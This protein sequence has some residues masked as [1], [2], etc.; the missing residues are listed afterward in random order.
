MILDKFKKG[1]EIYTPKSVDEIIND[2]QYRTQRQK[3]NKLTLI[4]EPV[5]YK[6]LR[7]SNNQIIIERQPGLFNPF[8]GFGTIIFD[9]ESTIDGTKINC[10]IDP[11]IK[12]YIG[13][14][15][16]FSLVPFIMTATLIISLQNIN[17][18]S[19][20]FLL[21][22]WTAFF[23]MCYFSL[24]FNRSN[25]INHSKTILYDLGL[26]QSEPMTDLNP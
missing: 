26:S 7:I 20:I 21:I 3:E 8:A 25:L 18:G 10:S 2:I 1:Y 24:A 23:A 16:F 13:S 14:F 11:L 19:I 12:Y 6:K 17:M 22:I 5:K 4:Y 15:C 9:L